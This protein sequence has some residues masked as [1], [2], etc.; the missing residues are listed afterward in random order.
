MSAGNAENGVVP[1]VRA[2]VFGG[3]VGNCNSGPQVSLIFVS[4]TTYLYFFC[5]VTSY[6]FDLACVRFGST[7]DSP[8][9]KQ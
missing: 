7:L 5:R 4:T 9:P 8:A 6:C 1:S 2:L 3:M